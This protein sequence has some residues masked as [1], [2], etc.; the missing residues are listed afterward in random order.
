[1]ATN[2]A[3]H[4]P[5]PSAQSPR[6]IR[7]AATARISGTGTP[8]WGELKCQRLP[9]SVPQIPD[10]RV[11]HR[12][13]GPALG[14]VH[15]AVHEGDNAKRVDVDLVAVNKPRWLVSF[16]ASD[17]LILPDSLAARKR[18]HEVMPQVRHTPGAVGVGQ[19]KYELG[20]EAVEGCNG[21]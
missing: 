11:A 16:C 7:A 1:V 15:D 10:G 4:E 9:A 3:R 19:G 20:V 12:C 5:H 13:R 8:Q 18:A 14:A 6:P 21:A 17:E 2:R